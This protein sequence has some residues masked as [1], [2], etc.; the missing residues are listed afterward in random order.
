MFLFTFSGDCSCK[1]E[2]FRRFSERYVTDS[3]SCSGFME[4]V[5]MSTRKFRFCFILETRDDA[6]SWVV[7]GSQTS[8]KRNEAFYVPWNEPS[9]H[10]NLSNF[11]VDA[12]RAE[13]SD[14]KSIELQT[15]T[16][17][18]A[19]DFTE[20]SLNLIDVQQQKQQ[21]WRWRHALRQSLRKVLRM[22]ELSRVAYTSRRRTL[23]ISRIVNWHD[24][25]SSP[26][27][28]TC[29]NRI[30]R[31][32]KTFSARNGRKIVFASTATETFRLMM[33]LWQLF[34]LVCV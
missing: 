17:Y 27:S 5:L 13:F 28:R 22:C 2:L 18:L 9:H 14:V 30:E 32:W 23:A 15:R 7:V 19:H 20:K 4:I 10:H 34:A 12:T 25:I 6:T 33:K 11:I 29:R 26:E 3:E 8:M 24:K 1:V 21:S 31:D 16:F